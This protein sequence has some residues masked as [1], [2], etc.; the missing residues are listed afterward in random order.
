MNFRD[1][2]EMI[3]GI[4]SPMLRKPTIETSRREYDVSALA[5]E[6]QD[7]PRQNLLVRWIHRDLD[8][9]ENGASLL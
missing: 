1:R 4:E 6:R 3:S 7:H 2:E 5:L 8:A 9:Q